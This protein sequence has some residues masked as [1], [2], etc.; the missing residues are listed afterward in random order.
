MAPRFAVVQAGYR[1]RFGHPAT[2]VLERYREAAITVVDS[3]HC[4]ALTWRSDSPALVRCVRI[5]AR[6]YWHWQP[7]SP[8]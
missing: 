7:V 3:P 8:P 2:V 1:N 6:R 5:E 4:G